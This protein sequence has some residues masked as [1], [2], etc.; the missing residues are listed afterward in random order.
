MRWIRWV[1]EN[2]EGNR[3]IYLTK[4]NQEGDPNSWIRLL[5]R[6]KDDLKMSLVKMTP[7]SQLLWILPWRPTQVTCHQGDLV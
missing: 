7:D 6:S 5:K 3:I 1:K 4:K 2:E